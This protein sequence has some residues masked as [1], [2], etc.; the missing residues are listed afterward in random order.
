MNHTAGH[1][2]PAAERAAAAHLFD[3][4][5]AA[6]PAEYTVEHYLAERR[7][8]Q[9]ARWPTVPLLP[10]A[11]R[12]VQHLHAHGVPIALATGSGRRNAAAKTAH[13]RAVFACFAGRV[14]CGD[15]APGVRRSARG[16]LG[17]RDADADGGAGVGVEEEEDVEKGPL[18]VR[19]M[20]GKPHPDVFLRAAGEVLGRDVGLGRVDGSE[21][22]VSEAQELERAKG[23]VFEDGVPGVQAALAGGFNGEYYH[24]L[25]WLILTRD[26]IYS[27][28]GTRRKTPRAGTCAGNRAHTEFGAFQARRM[29]FAA[30]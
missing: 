5:A 6:I 27:G 1:R 2:H 11:A 29:G 28:L 20:K 13:L 19:T 4:L 24:T 12:L 7:A 18:W 16:E 15:D 8:L 3:A 21:G 26:S 25:S 14:V 17:L 10:G 22:V 23:L 9:D 30:V